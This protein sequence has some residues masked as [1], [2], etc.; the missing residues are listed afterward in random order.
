MRIIRDG[1]SAAMEEL[2]IMSPPVENIICSLCPLHWRVIRL[3]SLLNIQMSQRICAVPPSCVKKNISKFSSLCLDCAGGQRLCS[4]ACTA[5]RRIRLLSDDVVQIAGSASATSVSRHQPAIARRPNL[6]QRPSVAGPAVAGHL[7]VRPDV[8][9]VADG[10]VQRR[11]D[12]GASAV[13]VRAQAARLVEV[14]VYS[15]A[16][17]V[18]LLQDGDAVSPAVL[19]V[20]PLDPGADA[21]AHRLQ[22]RRMRREFPGRGGPPLPSA[23]GVDF[24]AAVR[25]W[26]G[27]R[28]VGVVGGR[29]RR[30]LGLDDGPAVYD[31]PRRRHGRALG[32]HDSFRGERRRHSRVETRRGRRQRRRQ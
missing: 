2:R 12:A 29:R 8:P 3:S 32:Q 6:D 24:V 28:P 21:G 11:I 31:E 13:A 25:P 9:L 16:A 18:D 23:L 10:L 14:L 20:R 17:V 4:S 15:V 5:Q 1:V 26:R 22:V 19:G 7:G 30:R 27:R